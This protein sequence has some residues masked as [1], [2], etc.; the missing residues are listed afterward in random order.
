MNI[1]YK[2]L[3]NY[4]EIRLPNIVKAKSLKD[5]KSYEIEITLISTWN[6]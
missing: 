4:Y 2:T 5:N 1:S 3:P 6:K